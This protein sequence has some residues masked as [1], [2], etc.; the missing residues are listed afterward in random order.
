MA[1]AVIAERRERQIRIQRIVAFC[2]AMTTI[3][4]LCLYI[5]QVQETAR[6]YRFV[7]DKSLKNASELVDILVED[8]FDIEAKY[9][10]LTAD[11]NVC[12]E[13]AYLVK[14][15]KSNQEAINEFYYSCIKLPNQVRQHFPEISEAL[16]KI[17]DE[18]DEGYTDLKKIVDGFDK[19]DY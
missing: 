1:T 19:L 15:E 4:F 17:K 16:K 12:C 9:R 10:E 11:M 8:Q 3:I 13:M 14:M 18:K 2:L 6:N 5:F 7:Y